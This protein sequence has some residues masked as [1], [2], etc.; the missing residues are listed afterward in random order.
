MLFALHL[1]VTR[2]PSWLDLTP[3]ARLIGGVVLAALLAMVAF[4]ALLD[5]A[6]AWREAL[7]NALVGPRAPDLS[8]SPTDAAV[9]YRA[10]PRP[11]PGRTTASDFEARFAPEP[12]VDAE[13][14]DTGSRLLLRYVFEDRS[15]IAARFVPRADVWVLT[16][17]RFDTLTSPW[18]RLP[19][20]P[21]PAV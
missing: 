15:F 13:R 18:L 4:G 17:V 19:I 12:G 21:A 16:D 10:I 3:A 14:V 7:D 1:V 6:G 2:R 9:R 11:V 20:L 8:G 5:R